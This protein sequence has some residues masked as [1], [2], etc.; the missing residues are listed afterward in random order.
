MREAEAR[1]HKMFKI[2]VMWII[3]GHIFWNRVAN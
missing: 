3:K 1:I 2:S